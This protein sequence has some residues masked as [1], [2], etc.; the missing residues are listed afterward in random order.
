MIALLLLLAATAAAAAQDPQRLAATDAFFSAVGGAPVVV[1]P[2]TVLAGTPLGL[3]AAAA[4]PARAARTT[5]ACA[6]L[7]LQEPRCTYFQWC[8]DKARRAAMGLMACL[9]ANLQVVTRRSRPSRP[10]PC[11]VLR[12]QDGCP[13][14]GAEPLPYH[15]CL[16]LSG[17][18]SMLQ[19]Q[20][21]ARGALRASGAGWCSGWRA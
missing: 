12:L 4:A 6:A 8:P 21:V 10:P 18:C 15:G 17:N 5:E 9:H 13:D 1:A 20:V 19:P 3:P 2:E 14:A 16:L 7:C 11:T